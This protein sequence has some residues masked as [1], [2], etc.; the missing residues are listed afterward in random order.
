[1][2]NPAYSPRNLLADANWVMLTDGG[3]TF[4]D[5]A[6]GSK[7][8]YIFDGRPGT[9]C[10][11]ATMASPFIEAEFPIAVLPKCMA[12]VNHN[13]Q[14]QIHLYRSNVAFGAWTQVLEYTILERGASVFLQVPQ[15]EP[16][17][18]HWAIQLDT[19]GFVDTPYLGE[20]WLG[21][22][23]VFPRNTAWGSEQGKEYRTTTVEFETGDED[24]YLIGEQ[25]TFEADMPDALT[26]VEKTAIENFYEA[27][28]GRANAFLF[29]PDSALGECYI[30]KSTVGR[31]SHR[32]AGVGKYNGAV[33]SIAEI[34]WAK[35]VGG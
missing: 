24:S 21:D 2:G 22:L 4:I 34:P 25:K 16:A 20:W 8:D 17:A 10:R 6:P 26:L 30:A 19:A 3:P 31:Y 18:K 1:M 9:A 23:V 15:T 11:W 13:C 14:G 5:P 32:T 33:L 12:L 28:K 29:V 35:P 7:K 27:V